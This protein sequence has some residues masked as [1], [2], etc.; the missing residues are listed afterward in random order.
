MR[1]LVSALVLLSLSVPAFAVPGGN[2][3]PEPETLALI[4]IGMAGM[5]LARR[6]NK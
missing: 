4:A 2:A 3:V 6:K 5:I 1:Y